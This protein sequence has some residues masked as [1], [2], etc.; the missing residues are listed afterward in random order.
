VSKAAGGLAQDY[1][2]LTNAVI[3][4]TSSS[5]SPNEPRSPAMADPRTRITSGLRG[6]SAVPPPRPPPIKNPPAVP[7]RA[8]PTGADPPDSEPTEHTDAGRAAPSKRAEPPA[9]R[10]QPGRRRHQVVAQPPPEP[11]PIGLPDPAPPLHTRTTLEGVERDLPP[12]QIQPT[13]HRHQGPPRSS[14]DTWRTKWLSAPE[15]RRSSHME[16]LGASARDDGSGA[17][18]TQG[19]AAVPSSHQLVLGWFSGRSSVAESFRV[20]VACWPRRSTSR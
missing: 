8:A 13:Y 18:G 2:D 10:R 11:D 17:R 16:C 3:C 14:T 4:T 20:V 12:M 15:P 19:V 7:A 6:L 9:R 5:T 1:Q